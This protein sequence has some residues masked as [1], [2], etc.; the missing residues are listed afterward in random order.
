MVSTRKRL[1]LHIGFH[2]AGTAAIHESLFAARVGLR[3]HGV[4]YPQPLTGHPSHLD[5]ATALG[6]NPRDQHGSFDRSAVLERYRRLI[7]DSPPGTAIVLASE[8]FCLGNFLPEAMDN[9]QV[10]RDKLDV[11]LTV[12]ATV[13]HPLDFLADIYLTEL[14][15][16][17]TSVGFSTW[18]SGFDLT[19]ADFDHRLQVWRQLLGPADELEICDVEARAI[20]TGI[21]VEDNPDGRRRLRRAE[22]ERAALDGFLADAGL[23]PSSVPL[24]QPPGVALHP[25]LVEPLLAVRRHVGELAER[26]RLLEAQL[27]ISPLLQPVDDPLAVLLDPDTRRDLDAR[28][29]GPQ[30]QPTLQSDSSTNRPTTHPDRSEDPMTTPA[31]TEATTTEQYRASDF[32]QLPG[33][34]YWWHH[35]PECSYEPPLYSWLEDDEW[36][37]MRQ[38]YV[39]SEA[40]FGLGTGECSIPA[41]SMLQGLI[42]GNGIR[43]VVQLGHY[44]GYSTYLISLMMQRMGNGGQ[45]YSA[46]ID[47]VATAFTQRWVERF[48]ISETATLDVIDSSDPA[49]VDHARTTFDGLGP[50]LVFIDSS[51]MYQHTLKELDLWYPALQD[52]GFLILHDASTFAVDFD[53]EQGGGVKRAIEEW[54][55]MAPDKIFTINAAFGDPDIQAAGDDLVYVDGCGLGILQK[56][57]R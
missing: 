51:H 18:L 11:T 38:W 25:I 30:H 31:T 12:S 3:D 53:A 6:F 17:D 22:V 14:R 7:D 56:L 21:G 33:N 39:E 40:E 15:D 10:F 45:L 49:A 42:T 41:M 9:L 54:N 2:Q 23:D 43:R 29:P 34:R 32:A 27:D 35:R 55:L 8:E 46:D 36:N 44:L 13:R 4:I 20:D 28:L 24:I 1:I 50:Q 16:T 26:R 5:V 19:A 52:W 48:G 37:L 57:P 47:P